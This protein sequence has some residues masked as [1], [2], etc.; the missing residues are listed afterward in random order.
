M[1]ILRD[2]WEACVREIV[3]QETHLKQK[4]Y[5][6]GSASE[7]CFPFFSLDHG[8]FHGN[9]MEFSLQREAGFHVNF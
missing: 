3:K 4:L 9:G 2:K 6:L 7:V 5:I 8:T 1:P